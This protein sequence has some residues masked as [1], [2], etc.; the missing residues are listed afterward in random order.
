VRR[1]SDIRKTLRAA[2]LAAGVIL[3]LAG[4]VCIWQGVD[5]RSEVRDTVAREEIVG[6][7]D[8]SR[9]TFEGTPPAG[10][11]LPSCDVAGE[12]VDDGDEARCFADWMRVHALVATGGRTFAQMGRYLDRDGDEVNDPAK[13]AVDP[14]TGR[15]VE[16]DARNLWVTQRALATG[17][18][19]AF[20][21]DRL[22]LFSMATGGLFAL[23]GIGLLVMLTAGRVLAPEAPARA[24]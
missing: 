18:E 19:L 13:A 3:V 6:S 12:T 8:M 4:A 20:V 7:P 15:P 24:A 10:V 23:L 1:S 2:G 11:T 22:A 21:G 9:A 5:A 16:N 17:L 14:R